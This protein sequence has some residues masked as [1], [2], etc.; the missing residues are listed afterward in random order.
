MGDTNMDASEKASRQ[1]KELAHLIP[2]VDGRLRFGFPQRIITKLRY[3]DAFNQSTAGGAISDQVFRMNSVFDPDFTNLGHQPMWHDN[4]TSIYTYYRVHGSKLTVEFV[5]TPTTDN[6]TIGPYHIGIIG[7]DVST[8][9]T[10][11]TAAR[12]EMSDSVSRFIS[13]ED[14]TQVLEWQYNPVDKLGIP[15]E[16]DVA[17][18]Q[19]S[20]NPSQVYFAHIWWADQGAPVSSTLKIRVMLEFTVE[21]Y[22]LKQ[23]SIN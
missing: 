8:T 22:Q 15:A 2:G 13:R 4:Y 5:P 19:V 10:A 11:N 23:Q 18:A 7:S 3:S 12:G 1:D 20:S 14:G 21:Y 9:F 16:D 17:G 6:G